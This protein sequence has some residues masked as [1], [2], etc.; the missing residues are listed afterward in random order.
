MVVVDPTNFEPPQTEGNDSNRE[1]VLDPN[2][3]NTVEEIKLS[4]TDGQD[5]VPETA[6]KSVETNPGTP[7]G[8]EGQDPGPQNRT[9]P[10]NANPARKEKNDNQE[11]KKLLL[12]FPPTQSNSTATTGRQLL[13]HRVPMEFQVPPNSLEC[14][15]TFEFINDAL[16]RLGIN[17]H[18]GALVNATPLS[19]V[20]CNQ[21]RMVIVLTFDSEETRNRVLKAARDLDRAFPIDGQEKLYFTEIPR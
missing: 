9:H 16:V 13:I 20:A 14:P 3:D 2:I 19:Q 6:K 12:D 8:G 17:L 21:T 7:S 10:K 4:Q 15:R 1:L 5:P 11:P 18:R